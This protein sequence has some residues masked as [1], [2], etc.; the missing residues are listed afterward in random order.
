MRRDIKTK[1][2][3]KY[4]YE[5]IYKSPGRAKFFPLLAMMKQDKITI[6]WGS[7][8]VSEIMVDVTDDEIIEMLIGIWYKDKNQI[9]IKKKRLNGVLYVVF[10]GIDPRY[11]DGRKFKK[12]IAIK[13]IL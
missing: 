5:S 9:T 1:H 11:D 10:S 4:V 6:G 13:N 7:T 2:T 3:V 8:I 12:H